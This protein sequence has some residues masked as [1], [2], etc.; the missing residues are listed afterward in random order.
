MNLQWEAFRFMFD[1]YSSF[2]YAIFFLA[3]TVILG[4]VEKYLRFYY[5]Q[6]IMSDEPERKQ[7]GQREVGSRVNCQEAE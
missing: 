4:C 6:H 1:K 5:L 3:I 2:D 7:D